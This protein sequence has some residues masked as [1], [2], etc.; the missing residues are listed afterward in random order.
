MNLVAAFL[1]LYWAVRAHEGMDEIKAFA[2]RIS[3]QA[4][5][6]LTSFQSSG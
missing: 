3:A 2:N 6:C 5:C 4:G 1:G